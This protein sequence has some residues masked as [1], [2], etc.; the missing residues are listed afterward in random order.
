[1]YGCVKSQERTGP[2]HSAPQQNAILQL[3][4]HSC[5]RKL[6]LQSHHLEQLVPTLQFKAEENGTS[7]EISVLFW[8]CRSRSVLLLMTTTVRKTG[9]PGFSSQP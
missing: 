7:V 9:S 5:H 4:A 2:K 8:H 3:V 1:M 6:I